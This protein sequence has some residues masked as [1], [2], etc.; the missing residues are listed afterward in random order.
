MLFYWDWRLGGL[1]YVVTN[2][3]EKSQESVYCQKFVTA[4]FRILSRTLKAS[5]SP[6]DKLTDDIYSVRNVTAPSIHLN[7]ITRLTEERNLWCLV[8]NTRVPVRVNRKQVRG[9]VVLIPRLHTPSLVL[10]WTQS[11]Q[12][13]GPNE[14]VRYEEGLFKIITSA[15]KTS[16]NLK[17]LMKNHH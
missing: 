7:V 2:Q 16:L 1:F 6:P 17:N 13:P 14:H 9:H 12:N 11:R 8:L 3:L 10:H 4:T 15:S 5:L